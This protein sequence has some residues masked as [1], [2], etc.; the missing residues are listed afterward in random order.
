MSQKA[1]TS[2]IVT[3]LVAAGVYTFGGRLV[4]GDQDAASAP[5]GPNSPVTTL[6]N[7]ATTAIPAND[8]YVD[9]SEDELPAT[10]EPVTD[11]SGATGSNGLATTAPPRVTTP[12]TG[13][14]PVSTVQPGTTPP[15]TT[16]PVTTD[17]SGTAAFPTTLPVRIDGANVVQYVPANDTQ[18]AL[19][20][21]SPGAV[22][23]WIL[24]FTPSGDN[25]ADHQ[26]IRTALDAADMV[27]RNDDLQYF[28]G[29]GDGM[30]N[31]NWGAL[32]FVL[33]ISDW[34]SITFSLIQS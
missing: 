21:L 15:V 34:Q 28:L 26:R 4:D 29:S 19:Y 9:A 30:I 22:R 1:V 31:G 5:S 2:A 24:D 8:Q 6:L 27:V 16:G 3:L 13:R 10:T 11:T 14:P 7:P 20:G 25:R 12:T 18:A 33:L 32:R 23:S 17:P